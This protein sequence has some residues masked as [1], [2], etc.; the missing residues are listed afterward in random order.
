[1]MAQG[2][3][4]GDLARNKL[5]GLLAYD[6]SLKSTD[7][8]SGDTTLSYRSANRKS[9]PRWR[10]SAN[11]LVIDATWAAVKFQSQTS[12]V[13]PYCA[14]KKVE[15]RDVEDAELDPLHSRMRTAASAP[16]EH[17]TQRGMGKR[18]MWMRRKEI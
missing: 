14:R 6:K 8:Q 13:A 15:E 2:A 3:A 18:R 1:M 11:F 5:R 17:S 9:T 4:F 16:W 7:V 10:G 12:K